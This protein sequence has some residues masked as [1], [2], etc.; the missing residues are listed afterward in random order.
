MAWSNLFT[1]GR[2]AKMRGRLRVHFLGDALTGGT[3]DGIGRG[4][5]FQLESGF[6]TIVVAGVAG[7]AAD[8]ELQNTQTWSSVLW[9]I[10]NF[11]NVTVMSYFWNESSD[12]VWLDWIGLDL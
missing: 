12:H 9:Y 5:I 7:R 3:Q 11:T 8:I 4:D 10:I 1:K 2:I 6:F